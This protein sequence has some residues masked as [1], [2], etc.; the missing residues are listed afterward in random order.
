[1]TIHSTLDPLLAE[2]F[3]ADELLRLLTRFFEGRGQ[4]HLAHELP[5]LASQA[6]LSH[7]AVGLLDRHGLLDSAF[8]QDL[9]AERQ[10]RRQDIHKAALQVGRYAPPAWRPDTPRAPQDLPDRRRYTGIGGPRALPSRTLQA[11]AVVQGQAIQWTLRATG[12][13]GSADAEHTKTWADLDRVLKPA[14]GRARLVESLADPQVNGVA[15]GKEVGFALAQFLLGE[16]ETRRVLMRALFDAEGV[17]PPNDAVRLRLHLM[18][19]DLLALPWRLLA[20]GERWLVGDGWTVEYGANP[21]RGAQSLPNPFT[22]LL[23]AP[24]HTDRNP[25][26]G[27]GS[28]HLATALHHRLALAWGEAADRVIAHAGT[29]E[30][31]RRELDQRQPSAVLV[32][33]DFDGARR[34]LFVDGPAGAVPVPLSAL[35]EAVEGKTRLLWLGLHGDGDLGTI[36]AGL[37]ALPC[38]VWPGAA[39]WPADSGDAMVR[40]VEA[41]STQGADP[42]LALHQI[43]P[44]TPGLALLQAHGSAERWSITAIASSKREDAALLYLDRR[45][46]K[47]GAL[48]ELSELVRHP[49]HRVLCLVAMGGPTDHVP[50]FHEQLSRYLGRAQRELGMIQEWKPIPPPEALTAAA[51]ERGLAFALRGTEGTNLKER[52]ESYCRTRKGERKEVVVLWLN[53]G[54]VPHHAELGEAS[55]ATWITFAHA[56]LGPS[57]PD[58]LRIVHFLRRERPDTDAEAFEDLAAAARTLPARDYRSAAVHQEALVPIGLVPKGELTGFLTDATHAGCPHQLAPEVAAAVLKRTGGHFDKVVALLD[59]AERE[60]LWVALA[61]EAKSAESRRPRRL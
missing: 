32:H 34:E 37:T 49:L 41:I 21:P 28:Q 24:T 35:V 54:T 3:T 1:M 25:Q 17:E 60:D 55:L 51:L 9:L 38:A 6:D 22:I 45:G 13:Q 43:P 44:E 20:W 29:W 53:W 56:V 40:W 48:A 47:G 52:L 31:F 8:F 11:T 33:A 42:V 2:L 19:P 18:N 50:R 5:K 27:L 23:L 59:Q 39:L 58:D 7:Q 30:G 10:H 15:A 57:C 46:A 61:Q 12:R 4:P 16:P 36:P 26:Y 14:G